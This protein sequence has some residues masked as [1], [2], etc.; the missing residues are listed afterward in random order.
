MCLSPLEVLAPGVYDRDNGIHCM[1]EIWRVKSLSLRAFAKMKKRAEVVGP[2]RVKS[3]A[4]VSLV[5]GRT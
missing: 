2:G 4:P 3:P 5:R 1:N